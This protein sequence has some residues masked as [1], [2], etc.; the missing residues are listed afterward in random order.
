[1]HK[2]DH[3][4][5]MSSQTLLHV[6]AYRHHQGAHTLVRQ[7]MEEHLTGHHNKVVN[8]MHL[9]VFYKDIYQ[10]VQFNHQDYTG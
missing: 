8:L 6:S 1:M 2:I 9:L 4:I 10:N 5:V 7:N 3:F